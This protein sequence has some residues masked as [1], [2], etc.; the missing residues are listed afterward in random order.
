MRAG[1][2]FDSSPV[3]FRTAHAQADGYMAASRQKKGDN[4]M[5]TTT[6]NSGTCSPQAVRRHARRGRPSKAAK[7]M[8]AVA[9]FFDT[10]P[11]MRLAARYG[12]KGMAAAAVVMC[13]VTAAG[14]SM[15]WTERAKW[16]TLRSLPG[17][18]ADELDEIVKAMAVCGV[19]DERAYI[20][21]GQLTYAADEARVC[22]E[23]APACAEKAELC[24][25]KA[26]LCTK[27]AQP[28]EK[29]VLLTAERTP[30]AAQKEPV[31][32]AKG[33]QTPT[34]AGLC[35]EN[36][37]LTAKNAELCANKE[38]ETK[39]EK[40]KETTPAPPKER[41]KEINKEKETADVVPTSV[42]CRPQSDDDAARS[43]GRKSC[44][45]IES[46]QGKP[47]AGKKPKT[48]RKAD[49]VDYTVVRTSWNSMMQ[50]RGI[51]LLRS[52]ISGQR[53]RMFGARVREYGK[54][55]VW[56]VMRKV[57]ASSYLCGGGSRG[58]TATFDWMLRPL[59]F[60]KVLDGHYDND[61]TQRMR[62]RAVLGASGSIYGRA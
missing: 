1:A 42:S 23:A 20:S 41:E 24:T 36:A 56:L 27:E 21:S 26:E 5:T 28:R 4:S 25:E 19:T 45:E 6:T 29:G 22:T 7:A 11:M 46:K 9:A 37:E 13:A 2:F 61:R 30:F 54:D 51:P 15:E 57:A 38:K 52:E 49:T 48:V 34:N 58:F 33:L 14:G 60:Q 18:T 40:Q 39:Q 35:A 31:C 44:I 62:R 16:T 10:V 17:T 47:M 43:A 3:H 53:R 8:E 50:G 32:T 59:N 12:T 55:T